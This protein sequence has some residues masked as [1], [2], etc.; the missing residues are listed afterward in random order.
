MARWDCFKCWRT[1]L[2][3]TIRPLW[4]GRNYKALWLSYTQILQQQN[5]I[6]NSKMLKHMAYQSNCEVL[7]QRIPACVHGLG[8][9]KYSGVLRVFV[10]FSHFLFT[11]KPSCLTNFNPSMKVRSS[12]CHVLQIILRFLYFVLSCCPLW[13]QGIPTH[14]NL[15][16]KRKTTSNIIQAAAKWKSLKRACKEWIGFSAISIPK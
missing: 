9:P 12:P 7:G 11:K 15:E 10:W 6:S 4:P 13:A 1:T 2:Q 8:F 14:E 16:K 5:C 3:I